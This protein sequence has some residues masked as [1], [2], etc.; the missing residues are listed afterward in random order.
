MREYG[1]LTEEDYIEIYAMKQAGTEQNNIAAE[2]GVHPG[3]HGPAVSHEG[4]KRQRNCNNPLFYADSL[5][6][7]E[8]FAA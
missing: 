7:K 2:P 6:K 3:W 1:Q 5:L 4:Y 8:D